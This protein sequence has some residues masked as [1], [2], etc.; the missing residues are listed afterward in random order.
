M[1][2]FNSTRLEIILINK[3]ATA[4][5]KDSRDNHTDANE[6]KKLLITSKE[7]SFNSCA[8]GF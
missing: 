8:Q 6:N 3:E 4:T 5:T 7:N 2:P 1:D